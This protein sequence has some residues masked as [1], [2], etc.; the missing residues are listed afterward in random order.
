METSVAD[1][2]PGELAGIV[3]LGSLRLTYQS[4]IRTVLPMRTNLKIDDA[5]MERLEQEAVR[6]GCSVSDLVEK[7]LRGLLDASNTTSASLPPLPTFNSGGALVDI[8]DRDALYRT[9]EGF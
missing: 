5:L 8:S 7:A 9:M 4:P 6:R 1:R 3:D 2:L